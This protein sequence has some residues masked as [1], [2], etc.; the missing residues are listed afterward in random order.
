MNILKENK[1][2]NKFMKGYDFEH[3]DGGLPLG[4][5]HTSWDWLMPVVR[6]CLIGEAE[7]D[8]RTKH[9]KVLIGKKIKSVR[10]MSESEAEDWGWYSRPLVIIFEDNSLIYSSTDDEGNDGGALF[11]LSKDGAMDFPVI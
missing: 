7:Q 4:D 5:F 2:I 9:A 1:L 3:L 10:Y 6:Q 11:G 8:E